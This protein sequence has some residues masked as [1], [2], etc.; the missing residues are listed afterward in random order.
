[1]SIQCKNITHCH[2]QKFIWTQVQSFNWYLKNMF[3]IYE[4]S[5]DFDKICMEYDYDST[6]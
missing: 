4:V 3:I 1:M 6:L 5:I 2:N